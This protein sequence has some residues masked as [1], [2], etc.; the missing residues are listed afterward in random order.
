MSQ[1][2]KHI[3]LW[4]VLLLVFL[5]IFSVFSK[6]HGREPEVVFSEFMSSVERGEVQEVVIQGQN[7]QGKYKSGERF[8]SFAPNDPELVKSLRDRKVKIAAKPEDESPWYMVLL[9]NW[10]PMLLLIGVWI[11]F[12]R[13]MQ[14]GGGKAMS[15][16]KSRAKLLTENQHRVTFADVA[17]ADE[18][19]D[20]LQEIIAFLKDPKKFTKLGGRIPKG[21]L[22][23]GP[24]G[25]GKTLLA[26]AIA[27]E[28]GVPFFSISG[29]D[30]V[31]M[32]VGVGASRVRD[33]FVQGKKNAPCIIFIDEI[34]AVGRHRGAGLGGGHDEREQ[35]LNQLLVEMDGF[36]ANE[37]VILIA[38]TN[39]PDVLDPAL[40]RP[41]RFD[42]RVVVPRPDVKGREG[43]LQ[44]HT[45]KVP[46]AED[47]DIAV[48]A[49]ATPGFAGAD[50]ENLVNEAALL[51]ARSNK[52]KVDMG[53]FEVAKD[54][55]MM[56][57]ER[58]S[59]IISDEE[60]R[61]TAY[62]EAGHALV[63]KLLPG[64]DPVHK[65]TIIPRGMALGLTQQLP[66]DEKHTYQKDYLLNNLAILFGG[67]VAEEL[68]L[69]H[70]TTGAGNDIE[71]AT[72]LAHRMVCEWGMSEKLGPMTFGKKEEEIFLGRDFTQKV[73][74]SENTAIE[75]DAEIRRIIQDSY[76]RAKDL[77][78]KNLGL[79][80][81]IAE[82]LLEKEVLD[83]SEIDAIVREFGGNGGA[84][85]T[86]STAVAVA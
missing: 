33:L 47:V 23:V 69:N 42:R 32:F 20:D 40:L 71:K 39:R 81:K 59:M 61:V 17:G 6:Q 65:V 13:Q 21:C 49:R 66:I 28:A 78:K 41:G 48:L 29:S 16:G 53:D 58:R 74:Y 34:D 24:P 64:A 2:S 75:I 72:D 62:H 1:S 14:V 67:R 50:L 77:L 76:Q 31:E 8:R 56:G 46:V 25:T 10:F 19:K 9:L 63:A 36:E 84:P 54:K 7:I 73:D 80:H 22:L 27:G 52:E 82:S 83:G 35:T 5:V 26:R 3:A 60:K 18:A 86:P 55:V 45:R 12:M 15:F 38:A 51:A 79:L 57:A 43:I 68:V 30:F 11:F 4:L 44:V 70:M 85:L 37:G